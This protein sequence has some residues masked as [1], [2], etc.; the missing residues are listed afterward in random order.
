M[1]WQYDERGQVITETRTVDGGLGTFVTGWRYNSAGLLSEMIY[2]AD[3]LGNARQMA[4]ASG[5]VTLRR[6]FTPWG[7]VLEQQS[8]GDFAWGYFGG[9]MDAA[10]GLLYVGNGQYYDPA[11][12]RFLTREAQ[13]GKTNPYVPWGGPLGMMVGPLALIALLR[14][15]EKGEKRGRVDYLLLGLLV[16]LA[17]GMSLAGCTPEE[18]DDEQAGPP[19]QPSGG[20]TT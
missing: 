4:D 9:L 20:Q 11:T 16:V 5:N 13:E 19:T 17:V 3:G 6:S 12:G 14:R 2:P 15:R 7:E 10:T 18:E 8:M 1:T